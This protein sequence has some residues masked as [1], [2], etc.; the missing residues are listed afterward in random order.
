MGALHEIYVHTFPNTDEVVVIWIERRLANALAR[1][2]FRPTEVRG[3]LARYSLSSATEQNLTK[4]LALDYAIET[5]QPLSGLS[6]CRRYR[7]TTS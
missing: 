2:R 7:A 3:V 6:P 4:G 1:V 5:A